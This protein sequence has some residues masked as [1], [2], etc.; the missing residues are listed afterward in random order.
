MIKIASLFLSLLLANGAWLE[1]TNNWNSPNAPIPNAPKVKDGGNLANCPDN[2]RPAVFPEDELLEAAGWTLTGAAQVFGATKVI[3]AMANADGMC[4][5]LSYNVFVF[6]DG[7]FSG[8]LS[9]VE[10]SSRTDGSLVKVDLYREGYLSATFNRYSET[11]ALCCPSGSTQ[12]F[13]EVKME[14]NYPVL[15]PQLPGH[16]LTHR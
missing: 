3:T 14:D 9:P 12:V 8:T 5:L 15:V 1:D 16:N 6:T 2:N 10:M 7:Q 13:Y 11:D 4:R